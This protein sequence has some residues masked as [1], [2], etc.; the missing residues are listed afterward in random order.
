MFGGFLLI[1]LRPL[2]TPFPPKN[3]QV[4]LTVFFMLV[5]GKARLIKGWKYNASA[6]TRKGILPCFI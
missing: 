3:K 2:K 1:V 5:L 6:G 4:T